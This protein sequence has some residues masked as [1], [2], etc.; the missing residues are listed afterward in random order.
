MTN[1][2]GRAQA[3]PPP[4]AFPF[5]HVLEA[6][7]SHRERRFGGQ[8]QDGEVSPLPSSSCW[9]PALWPYLG[10][11]RCHS[12][13]RCPR[14]HTA[15]S[16][17][18]PPTG[19]LQGINRDL[20]V[21]SSGTAGDRNS[22]HRAGLLWDRGTPTAH[23][24]EPLLSHQEP[25]LPWGSQAEPSLRAQ[26]GHKGCTHLGE[27][28]PPGTRAWLCNPAPRRQ[29]WKWHL[30]LCQGL[31]GDAAL[32][33]DPGHCGGHRGITL[34]P[35]LSCS[36]GQGPPHPQTGSVPTPTHRDPPRR[37]ARAR[38]S[39]RA[40]AP[41]DR[42]SSVPSTTHS[43]VG[44]GTDPTPTAGGLL[45]GTPVGTQAG[46]E[47]RGIPA[48]LPG[49]M[50]PRAELP[51]LAAPSGYGVVCPSAVPSLSSSHSTWACPSVPQ[52]CSCQGAEGHC[53]SERAPSSQP[54]QASQALGGSWTGTVVSQPRSPQPSWRQTV[55]AV[56]RL[57]PLAH[58]RPQ[59]PL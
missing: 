59:V 45:L 24:Q 15:A 52:L 9:A 39:S 40:R 16:S 34:F 23:G 1:G 2:P 46:S 33:W 48:S 21:A 4:P 7:G 20:G 31:E 13:P 17:P 32:T 44:T 26:L 6:L 5:Q 19:N 49:G 3:V 28:A 56:P 14:C 55:A 47:A 51:V 10:L 25:E 18:I 54:T 11:P 35:L 38:H 12:P 29:R 30:Q 27:W 53:Q 58:T 37:R 42:H 8:L 22:Q 57:V 41:R 50:Q 43:T 36:A